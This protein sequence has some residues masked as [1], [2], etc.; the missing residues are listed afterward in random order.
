MT[1]VYLMQKLQL[2]DGVFSPSE[3]S[4]MVKSLIK[5][6]VNHHKLKQLSRWEADHSS[7][8]NFEEHQVKVLLQ[9][10]EHFRALC[11]TARLEGKHLQVS[12]AI[13]VELVE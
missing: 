9:E 7:D 5:E 12:G 4:S 1:T 2:I 8:L 10:N 6:Q 13:N 3:A 11:E